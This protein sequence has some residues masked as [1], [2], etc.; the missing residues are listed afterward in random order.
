MSRKRTRRSALGLIA[1]GAG[2][3]TI[4]TGGYTQTALDRQTDLDSTGDGPASA[5]LLGIDTKDGQQ[6]S[7]SGSLDIVDLQNNLGSTITSVA[8]SID[9]TADL[10]FDVTIEDTPDTLSPGETGSLTAAVSCDSDVTDSVPLEIEAEAGNHRITANRAVSIQCADPGVWNGGT[11]ITGNIYID[12][13]FKISGS[14]TID[15]NIYTAGTITLKSSFETDVFA[16][17]DILVDRGGVDPGAGVRMR[18]NGNLIDTESNEYGADIHVGGNV[19]M[20][21]RWTTLESSASVVASGTVD[22]TGD[23][24]DGY[25][26]AGA[27]SPTVPGL[28]SVPDPASEVADAIDRY[29]DANDNNTAAFTNFTGG[30]N[31]DDTLPAGDYY[32]AG[33]LTYDGDPSL[34]FETTNGEINLVV[35]GTFDASN[36]TMQINGTNRVNMYVK[37]A[38]DISNGSFENAGDRGDQ[39]WLHSAETTQ[40]TNISANP[41]YGIILSASEVVLGG[42]TPIHGSIVAS[43]ADI[44]GGQGIYAD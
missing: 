19:D 20:T 11:D 27:S 44:S 4:G 7:G 31:A 1:C 6:V 33:D 34:T 23:T 25:I 37:N 17:Q 30:Q 24:A 21:S 43:D 8:A 32:Y 2:L 29:D 18:A 39:F 42:G 26:E 9:P 38:I 41:F 5:A 14:I 35:D 28:E 22:I 10:D 16:G 3:L 12:G 36:L 40:A 13:D 15:G